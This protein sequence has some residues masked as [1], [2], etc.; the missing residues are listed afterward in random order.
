MLDFIAHPLRRSS[1]GEVSMIAI[2]GYY[3]YTLGANIHKLE[4]IKDGD[5]RDGWLYKLYLATFQLDG[6]MRQSVFQLKTSLAAGN[7][8]LNAIKAVTDSPKDTPINFMEAYQ[9]TSSLT[10]FEHVLKAEFGGA[11]NIYLV[12][13]KR[14]LDTS[15]LILN[16]EVC[17]QG[18]LGIKVPEAIV[19]IRAATRCV[20]FNLPTAAGF[21]LHRA[22][23][24][25]LHRWYDAVTGGRARPANRNI[26]DYLKVLNDNNWGD[27]KVRSAIKD[28]KDLHRNPLIHPEDSLD[29]IDDAIALMGSI[30]AVVVAMLRDIPLPLVPAIEEGVVAQ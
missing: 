30:Q 13:K 27:A 8:L 1:Q 3:L 4:E 21:H 5:E 6:L 24:S 19:D 25:V 22:H 18:D 26:G 9:I 20:A 10:E 7:A 2:D 16:G 28:L 23:E 17:F 11:S 29:S 12:L 15:D 14:G